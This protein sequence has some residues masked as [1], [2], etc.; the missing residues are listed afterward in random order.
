MCDPPFQTT[1][2]PLIFQNVLCN[3]TAHLNYRVLRIW[4]SSGSVGLVNKL[5]NLALQNKLSRILTKIKNDP[6][7]SVIHTFSVIRHTWSSVTVAGWWELKLKNTTGFCGPLKS[8]KFFISIHN[9]PPKLAVVKLGHI[10]Y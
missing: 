3:V 8:T 9:A 6:H 2:N 7:I 4:N 10:K 1:L 5:L